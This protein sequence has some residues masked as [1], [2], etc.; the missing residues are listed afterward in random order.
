MRGVHSEVQS[1]IRGSLGALPPLWP[2]VLFHPPLLC[3]LATIRLSTLPK[4]TQNP[5]QDGLQPRVSGVGENARPGLA[6][7]LLTP[8]AFLPVSSLLAPGRGNV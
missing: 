7:L 3:P 2:P 8:G 1:F 5:S 4:H 6:F